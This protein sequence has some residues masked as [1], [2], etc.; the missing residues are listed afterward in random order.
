LHTRQHTT[1]FTAIDVADN[2]QGRAALNVY[3]LRDAM[4]Q[5]RHP[6]FLRG[7]VN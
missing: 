6:R 3:L 5:H 7:Y 2:A 4:F 1:H